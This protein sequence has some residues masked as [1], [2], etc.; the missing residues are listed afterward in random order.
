MSRPSFH[1]MLTFVA[2]MGIYLSP[3]SLY[4]ASF[5][6]VGTLVMIEAVWVPR[7]NGILI[8]FLPFFFT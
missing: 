4:R 3:E 6:V 8:I 2:D 5:N 1:R 7:S